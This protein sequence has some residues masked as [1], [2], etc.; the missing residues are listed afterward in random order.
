MLE[1]FMFEIKQKKSLFMGE[2]AF[3][4]DFA[5]KRKAP[6]EDIFFKFVTTR[7]YLS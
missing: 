3:L 6:L 4:L 1:L 5:T 2:D 7:F